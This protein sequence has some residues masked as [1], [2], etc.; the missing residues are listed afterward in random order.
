MPKLNAKEQL[1]IN[2]SENPSNIRAAMQLTAF[3]TKKTFGQ[4]SYMYYGNPKREKLLTGLRH[5]KT[6]FLTLTND[7]LSI[8]VKRAEVLKATKKD[9]VLDHQL[10]K[11]ENL[12]NDEKIALV[13]LLLKG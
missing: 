4:I 3:Q 11:I 13:D 12:T 9:L 10:T 8:N 2:V 5:N 6:M 7:G 1:A